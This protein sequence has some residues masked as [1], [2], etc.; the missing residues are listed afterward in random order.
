MSIQLVLSVSGGP[1]HVISTPRN[2][3]QIKNFRKE[4]VRETRLS[5][6]A[7]FNTYQLGFQ[8]FM[9]NRKGEP[10]DFIRYFSVHPT[11]IVHLIA[12]PLIEALEILLKISP[13]AVVLHYD[14]VFNMGDFYLS[15]ILFRH[16]LF[17]ANPIVPFGFLIH[18]RRFHDD[19]V[20]FLE[21]IRQ[22]VPLL[23][24]RKVVIVTDREFKFS[25][26]F[27]LGVHVY[28]WNHLE[29][30]LHFYLK[31]NANCSASQISYYA[32]VFKG[33]MA[34]PTEVEFEESW[35]KVKDS[36]HFLSNH[37]VKKYFEGKLLPAFKVHSSIWVLKS[38]GILNAENG[39]TN[40]AA[41]SVNAV[42]HRLN[43]WKQVPLD[44]V[45]SSLY[46]L[47]SYYHHEIER[48][49]HQCGSW[50][51]KDAYAYYQR[52]PALMPQMAK[53]IDPKDIVSQA[54]GEWLS[55][56]NTISDIDMKESAKRS[57]NLKEVVVGSSQIGLA[58]D[59]VK[60]KWVS[61]ADG[62]C[63]I[64]R[65]TDG[66]TPFAVRL[67][68]KETCSCAALKSCYHILACKL[69]TG[70]AIDDCV[71]TPNL[72]VLSQR[73]R[74]KKKEKPSGRKIPR[75]HDFNT[76]DDNAVTDET[77]GYI[78]YVKLTIV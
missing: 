48:G 72:A 69:M 20:H 74:K 39:V 28:C 12:Q 49:L 29:N 76:P 45:C 54:R 15:T 3:E 77:K 8:L 67:F 25:K 22:S 16:A 70:Q 55:A 7:M 64:V 71:T 21:I 18:S 27:S 60:K 1:R 31:N 38:A 17:E 11:V 13:E 40:N 58:H 53:P 61:L 43:R 42:L 59:A 50:Q 78:V 66:T 33:L 6:D 32:N 73:N 10:K 4:V 57:K 26:V 63:W 5:H 9:N 14:T 23:A 65:G 34:E 41:E 46:H 62:G 2:P 19:H 51:L 24:S 36:P 52:D 56:V 35:N 37:M 44:I 75:K 47:S 30:D 68:P